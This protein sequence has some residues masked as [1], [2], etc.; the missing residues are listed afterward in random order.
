MPTLSPNQIQTIYRDES[1]EAF[2]TNLPLQC[3]DL[4]ESGF[5]DL[6]PVDEI[7]GISDFKTHGFGS[8][9]EESARNPGEPLVPCTMGQGYTYF[10]AIRTEFSEIRSIPAEYLDAAFKLKPYARL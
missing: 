4:K 3:K 1:Y 8:Y 6:F 2:L 7:A 5:Y 10:T 9:N